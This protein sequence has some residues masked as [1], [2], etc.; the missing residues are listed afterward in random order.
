MRASIII[1]LLGLLL[2]SPPQASAQ[3]SA[4]AKPFRLHQVERIYIGDMGAGD[5]AE[6]FRLLLEDQLIKKGFVVVDNEDRADAFLVGVLSQPVLDESEGNARVTVQ[7]RTRDGDRL[8]S[9][10][11]GPKLS[12]FFRIK[13]PLQLRAEELTRRLRTDW[14]KS[15]QNAGVKHKS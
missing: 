4:S 2:L 13:D 5:S 7:L 11:F 14:E 3:T 10:N 9:G 12:S 1:L 8:W 15:A 6:R